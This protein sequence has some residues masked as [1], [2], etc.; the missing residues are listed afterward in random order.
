MI[1]RG[2][3]CLVVVA[4]LLAVGIGNVSAAQSISL[5][6]VNNTYA[7]VYVTNPENMYSYEIEFTITNGS[8]NTVSFANFFDALTVTRG[9]ATDDGGVTLNVYE[10]ILGNNGV[11]VTHDGAYNLFN[12]THT[13]TFSLKGNLLIANTKTEDSP[14]ICGN[15]V[16]ETGETCST[17]SA[18]AG[19]CS[20]GT[21]S[22]GGGGGGGITTTIDLSTIKVL[23]IPSEVIVS[24]AAGG[25]EIRKITLRNNGKSALTL[26]LSTAGLNPESFLSERS[27]TLGAG[28]QKEIALTLSGLRKGVYAGKI[29]ARY[30]G[31]IVQ[32]IPIIVNMKSDNFL[33]DSRVSLENGR[34]V[35]VG[36]DL[37]AQIKLNE[38]SVKEEPVD[39][40][41]NYVIKGFDGSTFLDE[42]ETFAVQ[43]GTTYTKSFPTSELP[44]GK[45]VF[46]I[47]V[48]Y[49]GAFATSSVQFSIVTEK[50]S[51]LSLALIVAVIMVAVLLGV[52]IWAKRRK[53][54]IKLKNKKK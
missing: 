12:V 25:D 10:S 15:G 41:V 42:S 52:G 32:E 28:E 45:Y 22:G 20:E 53:P 1:K 29:I 34:Y 21:S 2:S 19:D 51:S 5:T 16:I 36:E 26:N 11:G 7:A 31:N 35:L 8:T 4:L 49:P 3:L 46:A 43:G 18:D 24:V 38:V 13:G 50:P 33:F 47:E 30:S 6:S 44:I 54:S 14:A 37:T 23:S 27:V 48:V 17:C 40:T 39:V 9:S